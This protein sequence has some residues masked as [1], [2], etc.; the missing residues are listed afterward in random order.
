MK[1]I[2]LIVLAALFVACSGDKK[3]VDQIA[4][5]TVDFEESTY[6]EAAAKAQQ[7]KRVLLVDFYSDT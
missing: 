1:P 5:V 2:F 3:E 6:A 4:E 7:M